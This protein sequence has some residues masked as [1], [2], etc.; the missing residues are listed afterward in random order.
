M[1]DETFGAT[2]RGLVQF[3]RDSKAKADK[4][5]A[6]QQSSIL[7]DRPIIKY[8]KSDEAVNV[9]SK[10]AVVKKGSADDDTLL[11]GYIPENLL[12]ERYD[13]NDLPTDTEKSVQLYSLGMSNGH[14]VSTLLKEL[15]IEYD[16]HITKCDQFTSG[17]VK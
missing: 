15:G 9:F 3:Y 14:K 13:L 6:F 5:K 11:N 10:V 4:A 12:M 2:T 17:F 7:S 1:R 8:E 16:A